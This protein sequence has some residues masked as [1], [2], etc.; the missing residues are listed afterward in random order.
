[1]SNNLVG[2]FQ[3]AVN[4]LDDWKFNL[5]CVNTLYQSVLIRNAAWLKMETEHHTMEEKMSLI[6]VINSCDYY[7]EAASTFP[8]VA[9]A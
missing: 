9:E 2:K 5:E 4:N 1:M 7:L 6:N 3:Q 8:G